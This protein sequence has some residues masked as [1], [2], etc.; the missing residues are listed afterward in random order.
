MQLRFATILLTLTLILPL[1]AFTSVQP[2][3]GSPG[4]IRWAYYVPYDST[5]LTSLKQNLSN[6]D[7]VSPFWFYIDAQGQIEDKNQNEVTSLLKS[8]GVKNLPTFRNQANGDDFH[9][10]LADAATRKRAIDNTVRLVD[11]HGYDGVN[12]DFE[13]I[14][15]EDRPN[16]TRFMADLSTALHAKGKLVTQAVP[17]R[18]RDRNDGWAGAF[19]YAGL[20]AHNDLILIMSYGYRTANSTVPGSTAPISWVEA[21]VAYAVSQIPPQKLLLGVAWYGYDW[22]TTAGPPATALRYDQT[23]ALINRF[24]VPVEYDDASQ[25]ALIKYTQNGQ[26]H[27][28]WYEDQRSVSAK[29][30]LVNKYGLAGVGGWRLGQEDPGTWNPWGERLAYRTWYLAEGCT[31]QPFD[32][33]VLVMNPNAAEASVT[34]T[35]M[36]EDGATVQRNYKVAAQSRFN[37]FANQ[38]VPNAAVS[39]KVESD[40]PVLVE[41]SMYFGHDGHNTPGVNGPSRN[42]YMAEGYTGPGTDTW[43]LIMNPNAQPAKA[44]VTLMKEDGNAVDRTY[45][46]PPTSRLS[47]YAN[48]IVPG[49]S[50]STRVTADQPVVVERAEYFG[51]GGGHG[52]M[53]STYTAKTWYLPEG[54]TGQNTWVLLM[55][56]GTTAA[57]ATVTFM[58]DDGRNISR[59][60]SLRPTSR[61]TINVND[62]LPGNTAFGTQIVA[63]QPVLAERASY[64]DNGTSGDSSMA[65]ANPATIWYLAEGS[66]ASPFQEFVLVM[67]PNSAT[68]NLDVTYMLEGGGTV[69]GSYAVGA[70]SRFTVFVNQE[71]P[72][73]A[74]SVRVRS[75]VPVVVERVMY[76]GTGGHSSM[77]IGE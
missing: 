55:N 42:W 35:F 69:S 53:G 60:Y 19:D 15:P 47:V 11:A 59:A 7:Y 31:C 12:I 30:D 49:V 58:T 16:L 46:L 6:L 13:D 71:V 76:S 61:T 29:L 23:Q 39:T 1:Q 40:L 33:W 4:K 32:T 72:N 41:R 77:G 67:N 26:D 22:N 50:F 68:A 3:T 70:K 63:D 51:Q 66:T 74:L 14:K 56:P 5:S 73:R 65:A 52:S 8:R 54:F 64:W 21:T 44:T 20:A 43:V 62:I 17:A 9:G 25:T 18:D 48:E 37:L 45:D 28:A 38:V 27:Q 75:D 10:V 57:K 34:V 24:S 36:K 2:A